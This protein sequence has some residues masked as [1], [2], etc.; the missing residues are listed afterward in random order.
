M[1]EQKVTMGFHDCKVNSADR[2]K[3]K[4]SISPSHIDFTLRQALQMLWMT[5]PENRKTPEAVEAEFRRL[6]ERVVR[7]FN[8]DAERFA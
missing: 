6:V 4:A 7:D 1:A 8:E 5:L 2:D 3:I